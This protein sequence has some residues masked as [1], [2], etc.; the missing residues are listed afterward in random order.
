MATSSGPQ[1]TD[2]NNLATAYGNVCALI[3]QVTASAQPSYSENG[4]SVSKTEY[5]AMLIDKQKAL[6]QALQ[7]ANDA[8]ADF[9]LPVHHKTFELSR[10]PRAEPITRLLLAAGSSPDR[11]VTRDIGQEFHRF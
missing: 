9:I 11:V 10:E 2:A 5:L 8:G 3:A 6:L 1:P 7:M 4:R